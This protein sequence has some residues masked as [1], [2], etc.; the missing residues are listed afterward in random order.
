[1][2]GSFVVG[3]DSTNEDTKKAI[4]PYLKKYKNIHYFYHDGKIPRGGGDNSLFLLNHCTGE[5][6]NYLFHDDLFYP[7]KIS[8]MMDYYIKDLDERI[9]LVTSA[10]D[11]IDGD[12]KFMGRQNPWQPREDTILKGEEVGRNILFTVGNIIGELTTVIVRKRDLVVKNAKG[13]KVFSVSNFCGINS[14]AYGDLDTWYNVLRKGDM[15]FIAESLSA[16]RHHSA[17]NTNQDSTKLNLPADALNFVTIAWINNVF[18]HSEEEFVY[19]CEKWLLYL[20]L[21]VGDTF[22]ENDTE[23][24]KAFKQEMFDIRDCIVNKE[25][26]EKIFNKTFSFLYNHLSDDKKFLNLAKKNETTG[27]WEKVN[28]GLSYRIAQKFD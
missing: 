26:Y 28:D 3:D 14:K 27:L 4:Q 2:Y 18:L 19:C 15:V 1:M 7:E 25:G 5:Y 9:S 21:F 16:F 23:E 8:K 11:A 24:V 22:K 6:V 10:R 13:E 20:Q 17:Q 12:G